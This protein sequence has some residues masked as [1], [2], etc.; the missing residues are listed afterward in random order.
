MINLDGNL[1]MVSVFLT[2]LTLVL[3]PLACSTPVIEEGEPELRETL[4]VQHTRVAQLSTRVVEL[5][6]VNESQWEIL[7]YLSTQMPYALDLITPVPAGVTITPTQ[8]PHCTPPACEEGEVYHCPGECPGG[9]GTVCATP[10]PG[11]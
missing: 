9:C 11:E 3:L 7:S 6:R 10:T 5:E 1:R 4:S 8:F 2:V